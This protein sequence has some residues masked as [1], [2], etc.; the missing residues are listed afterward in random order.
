MLS[1]AEKYC[2]E[3]QDK[4]LTKYFTKLIT[5][6]HLY[7]EKG[8]NSA[9]STKKYIMKFLREY[10]NHPELDAITVMELIPDDWMLNDETGGGLYD[11]LESA[12]SHTLH[13]KR[14]LNTAKHLS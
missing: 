12:I 13:Q 2:E 4:T 3:N 8:N 7:V 10:V 5:G 1:A 11:F 14:S 9:V 6:Y